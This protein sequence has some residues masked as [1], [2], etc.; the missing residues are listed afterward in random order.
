MPEQVVKLNISKLEKQEDGNYAV[1][2]DGELFGQ[3]NAQTQASF[4]LKSGGILKAGTHTVDYK[5]RKLKVEVRDIK[6]DTT[7]Y[8]LRDVEGRY[9]EEMR[10]ARRSIDPDEIRVRLKNAQRHNEET[11]YEIMTRV[12]VSE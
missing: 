6:P 12:V 4:Y 11:M 8:D 9:R 10:I 7:F 3:I 2:I 5:G 1:H